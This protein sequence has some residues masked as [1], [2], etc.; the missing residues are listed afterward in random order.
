MNTKFF[1]VYLISLLVLMIA[2]CNRFSALS[3]PVVSQI[4]LIVEAR[5]TVINNQLN[6]TPGCTAQ[7]ETIPADGALML[8]Q[9]TGEFSY[10][11]QDLNLSIKDQDQFS[12]REVCGGDYS[13]VKVVIINTQNL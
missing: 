12:Y 9:E 7:L 5:D 4:S 6:L 3:E 8:N 2:G 11:F 10:T 1:K 13:F